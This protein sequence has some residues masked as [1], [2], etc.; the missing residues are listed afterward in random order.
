[1][2]TK[3]FVTGASLGEGAVAIGV[4]AAAHVPQRRQSLPADAVA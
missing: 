3:D 1:M 4:W 2:N